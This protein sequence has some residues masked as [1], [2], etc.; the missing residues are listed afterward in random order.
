MWP[1]AA[2]PSN[3]IHVCCFK[4]TCARICARTHA[5]T[6]ARTHTG[7]HTHTHTRACTVTRVHRQ[8]E[9][10]IWCD[11][12][13]TP[14]PSAPFSQDLVGSHSQPFW[15][16]TLENWR[17]HFKRGSLHFWFFFKK[18][19]VSYLKYDC[20]F[21]SNFKAQIFATNSNKLILLPTE[22]DIILW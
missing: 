7:T 5:C 3:L 18:P 20:L 4:Y 21:Y 1:L 9:A 16:R 11:Q 15:N 17:L 2:I 19:Y 8:L 22:Q 10:E 6:H 12:H 13:K 14:S